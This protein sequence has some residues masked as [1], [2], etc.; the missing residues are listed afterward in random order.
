MRV[1]Q[2]FRLI[3]NRPQMVAQA[4]SGHGRIGNDLYAPFDEAY[5]EALPQRIRTSTRRSRCSRRRARS[6][7]TIDLQTTNGALG[8]IEGAQVFAQQA[9]AAGVTINVKILDG[10]AVLRR[11]VPEVAVLDRLLGLAQLP[12]PGRGGQP[13]DL[14]VQRDALAR[15]RQEVHLALQRRR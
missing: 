7:L 11:P 14:A 10:G 4:L 6:G 1:R 12:L 3:A 2:A 15:P 9:K 8:M 5:A 13:A